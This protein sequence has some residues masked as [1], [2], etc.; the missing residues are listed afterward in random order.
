MITYNQLIEKLDDNQVQQRR[1][2][3]TDRIEK[4]KK[5]GKWKANL[6]QTKKFVEQYAVGAMSKRVREI[7]K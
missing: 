3:I 5:I 4:L 1:Q 6:E 7:E 2:Q